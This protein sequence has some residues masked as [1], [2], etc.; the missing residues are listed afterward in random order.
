MCS[1]SL[2]NSSNDYSFC[3]FLRIF[4]VHGHIIGGSSILLFPFQHVFPFFLVLC[5]REVVRRHILALFLISER[6]FRTKYDICRF[7]RG[8]S[9]LLF[10]VCWVVILSWMGVFF[11]QLLIWSLLFFLKKKHWFS[12]L[13]TTS[14][15]GTN[16][17]WIRCCTY[18]VY[19]CYKLHNSVI[20]FAINSC[21][22]KKLQAK[23]I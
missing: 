1:A 13:E 19:L 12:N 17:T 5:W 2:L 20:I 23:K 14:I 3:R 6:V 22:F 8:M 7:F 18:Y 16:P 9:S 10:P 4:H 15:L 11:V 21:P